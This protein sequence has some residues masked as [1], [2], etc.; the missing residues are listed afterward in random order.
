MGVRCYYI[1]LSLVIAGFGREF[2][3]LKSRIQA[4]E[5]RSHFRMITSTGVQPEPLGIKPNYRNRPYTLIE[6]K[7]SLKLGSYPIF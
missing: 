1:A 4:I 2:S 5:N 6:R 3:S 7:P